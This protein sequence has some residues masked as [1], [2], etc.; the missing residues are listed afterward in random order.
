M[1]RMPSAIA[2]LEHKKE[3]FLKELQRTGKVVPACRAVRIS[4]D[5]IYDWIRFSPTFRRQFK[6][7]KKNRFDAKTAELSRALDVFLRV[8]EP[9]LSTE[10]YR[11]V[12]VATTFELT[13]RKF[14]EDAVSTGRASS[15]MKV[16][17]PS[18]DVQSESANSENGGDRS[19]TGKNG[20]VT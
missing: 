8:V 2:R 15:R 19:L 11:K 7:A 16:R 14:N 6:L 17:S 20:T 10:L 5:A 3:P 4:P 1:G 13:K 18:F 12:V 9:L